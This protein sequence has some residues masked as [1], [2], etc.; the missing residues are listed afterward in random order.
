[1]V[2]FSSLYQMPPN[3]LV[4]EYWNYLSH[5]SRKFAEALRAQV[6]PRPQSI[7]KLHKGFAYPENSSQYYIW[8]RKAHECFGFPLLQN[9]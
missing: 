2:P 4:T 5:V 9:D 8:V 1:M 3:K 6:F 7:I